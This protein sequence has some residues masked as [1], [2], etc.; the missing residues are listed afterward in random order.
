MQ[1]SCS[2]TCSE[3]VSGLSEVMDNWRYWVHILRSWVL[4]KSAFGAS[5]NLTVPAGCSTVYSAPAPPVLVGSLSAGAFKT[6]GLVA[7]E[8]EPPPSRQPWLASSTIRLAL[9]IPK[10]FFLASHLALAY[11]ARR[12]SISLLLYIR[13]RSRA[14]YSSAR[15]TAVFFCSIFLIGSLD[16]LTNVTLLTCL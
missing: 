9:V 11:S 16:G 6:T 15:L 2:L 8:L 10:L 7:P 13:P 12:C 5:T 1:E 14:A 3:H 4:E